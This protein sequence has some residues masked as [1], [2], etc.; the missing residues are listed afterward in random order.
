MSSK[1]SSFGFALAVTLI[2]SINLRLGPFIAPQKANYL[3]K[4]ESIVIRSKAIDRD[5][6]FARLDDI[7]SRTKRSIEISRR[8]VEQ[9]F[10]RFKATHRNLYAAQR[11]QEQLNA[12]P[13]VKNSAAVSQER[14]DLGKTRERPEPLHSADIETN[15]TCDHCEGILLNNKAYLVRTQEH[16]LILLNMIVCYACHLEAKNLGLE[17]DE[18]Q[19]TDI[20]SQLISRNNQVLALACS[21]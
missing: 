6:L 12:L 21:G 2:N 16:G 4:E 19:A 20:G 1:T 10:L 13:Y 14:S 17:T 8:L 15:S 9:S 11:S 3:T 7:K 18:L 5:Q